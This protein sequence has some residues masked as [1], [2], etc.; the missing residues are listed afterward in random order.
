M[1]TIIVRLASVRS[2]FAVDAQAIKCG[3]FAVTMPDGAPLD[4]RPETTWH[5]VTHIATGYAA[6]SILGRKNAVKCAHA[7][8][9]A[10]NGE[11]FTEADFQTPWSDRYRAWVTQ[12]KAIAKEYQA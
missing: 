5:T 12:C 10:L 9:K 7:F 4:E 3:Y 11:N 8:S 6:A 1:Q 2:A